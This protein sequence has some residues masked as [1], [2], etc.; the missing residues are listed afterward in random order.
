MKYYLVLLFSFQRNN[1]KE[2]IDKVIFDET[3]S[4]LKV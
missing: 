4:M 1:F 3:I 2:I